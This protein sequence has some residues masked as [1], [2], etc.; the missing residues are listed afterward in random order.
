[1]ERKWTNQ[2]A[3]FGLRLQPELKQ[4]IK[5]VAANNARSQN[6]EIIHRLEES[7]RAFDRTEVPSQ[8]CRDTI[9]K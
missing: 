7:F 9:R 3:P 4:K 8:T 6:S 2:I 5:D 1:M